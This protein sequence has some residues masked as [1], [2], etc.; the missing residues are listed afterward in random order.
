MVREEEVRGKSLMVS[1]VA[2]RSTGSTPNSLIEAGELSLYGQIERVRILWPLIYRAFIDTIRASFQS[3]S[4]S[5]IRPNQ[6][7][8][9]HSENFRNQEMPVITIALISSETI[10]W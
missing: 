3:L 5:T 1:F 8:L 9:S 4:A 2:R 6:E 7:N 10:R